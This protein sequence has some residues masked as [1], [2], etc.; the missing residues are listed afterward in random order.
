MDQKLWEIITAHNEY[1]AMERQIAEAIR[2]CPEDRTELGDTLVCASRVAKEG[3]E[4]AFRDLCS[5]L[6]GRQP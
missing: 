3:K 4:E 1:G 6:Y 2:D 5:F